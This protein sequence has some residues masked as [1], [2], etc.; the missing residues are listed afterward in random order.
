MKIL[1]QKDVSEVK[2]RVHGLDL[3]NIWVVGYG[4]YGGGMK[5]LSLLVRL[6]SKLTDIIENWLFLTNETLGQIN[7]FI[8]SK[9]TNGPWIRKS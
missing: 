5:F 9:Q 1:H 6:I 8:T 2:R 7:D 3:E 4:K